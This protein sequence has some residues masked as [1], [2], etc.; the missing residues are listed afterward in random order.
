MLKKVA[1]LLAVSMTLNTL[2]AKQLSDSD[3]ENYTDKKTLADIC[4]APDKASKS[5]VSKHKLSIVYN[6]KSSNIPGNFV[7]LLGNGY[8]NISTSMHPSSPFILTFKDRDKYLY[9]KFDKLPS[10]TTITIYGTLRH[11]SAKKKLYYYFIIEDF[12]V[13]KSQSTT[14][15][16]FKKSEY[17]AISPMEFKL[18]F[19]EYIDKKV[20]MPLYPKEILNRISPV[21]Q[22]LA[23]ITVEEFCTINT[24]IVKE[25]DKLSPEGMDT[26]ILGF[27]VIAARANNNITEPLL[28]AP[29]NPEFIF[30]GTLKKIVNPTQPNSK[31]VYCFFLD[32]ITLE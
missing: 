29:D 19:P 3:K 1:Y 26:E 16:E 28:T 21:Y 11:K 13:F 14:I 10:N 27:D 20:A 6:S 2:Y 30:Y 23:G 7:K 12:E 25:F 9:D 22:R 4:F 15:G 24:V 8:I 5:P 31:P 18:K 32:A 17:T